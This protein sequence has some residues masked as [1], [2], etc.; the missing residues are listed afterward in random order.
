MRLPKPTPK[1]LT[2]AAF[3]AACI[4]LVVSALAVVWTLA[5]VWACQLF[6]TCLI[7]GLL[8]GWLGSRLESPGPG[9]PAFRAP[10]TV[11]RDTISRPVGETDEAQD[12]WAGLNFDEA[13]EHQEAKEA[14]E[15]QEPV[16]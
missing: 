13:M 14:A 6:V 15:A 8:S 5:A 10:R 12:E 11:R 9:A 3:D 2:E 16:A 7:V 4:G 1:Q